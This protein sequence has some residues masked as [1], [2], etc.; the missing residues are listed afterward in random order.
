MKDQVFKKRSKVKAVIFDMD[1]LLVDS[2][3]LQS[4]SIELVL[5]HY[6]KTPVIEEGKLL[7]IVGLAGEGGYIHILEKYNIT[8]DLEIVRKKRHEI[9]EALISKKL[10][11]MKGVRKLINILRKRKIKIAVASSRNLKH[12][13]LTLK[14]LG[15]RNTFDI[16][17]GP[18]PELKIKPAPDLYLKTAQ[19]LE[20]KPE[21][22]VVL[23][24]SETGIAAGKNARMKIIAVP[25]IY[26]K[27]HNL[28]KADL[29]VNSLE[30]IKWSTILNI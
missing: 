13:L 12:I 30:D 9:Y 6:G 17:I 16:V 19:E 23:E 8:E 29:I 14:S 4:K 5:K 24:D 3:P 21:E 27:N 1:G 15:L 2:E 20:V 10:K 26:T 11:P 25:N 28:S 7:H 22:V 18:S